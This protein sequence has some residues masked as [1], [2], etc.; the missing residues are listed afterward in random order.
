[1]VGQALDVGV[2]LCDDVYIYEQRV[3]SREEY[4]FS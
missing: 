1:V 4:V 3:M 2:F